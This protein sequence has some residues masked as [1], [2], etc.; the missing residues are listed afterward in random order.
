MDNAT[1]ASGEAGILAF[2]RRGVR[3][4]DDRP[5]GDDHDDRDHHDDYGDRDDRD[6]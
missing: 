5:T 4:R 2:D 6:D 1:Q 3:D